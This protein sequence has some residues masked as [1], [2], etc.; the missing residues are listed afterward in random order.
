MLQGLKLAALWLLLVLPLQ[1]QEG[2]ETAIE[3]VIRDQLNA[4]QAD[5]FETAFT[6]ASPAI[7]QL[8]GSPE[9]F[10]AMVR[11]GYPMVHRPADVRFFDLTEDG[12]V[13]RQK[14][15][16]RDRA[17]QAHLLEYEMIATEAGWRI[18]GVRF[19]ELPEVGV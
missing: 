1:A 17:G 19:L 18:N 2:A 10:G 14:V 8:F 9:N 12:T 16:I 6:F 3:G 15:F 5:D 11:N 13:L 4:L 7:R